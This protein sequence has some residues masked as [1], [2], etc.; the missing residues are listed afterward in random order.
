[1]AD[2]ET[3]WLYCNL[4][5]VTGQINSY[6]IDWE[7]LRDLASQGNSIGRHTVHH[8]DLSILNCSQQE[9]ELR[10]SKQILEDKLG[11][12]I[13]SFSFP[14]GK[15]NKTTLSLL[16]ELGYALSFTTTSR[17]VHL[18]DNEYLLKRVHI[19]GGMPIKD[20]IEQLSYS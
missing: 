8:H 7:Q 12:D 14:Y 17:R 10:Q 6:N 19:G 20:F 3:A 11:T 4:F 16:P 1:M 5:V 13:K 2:T 9:S 18:G 15:Y